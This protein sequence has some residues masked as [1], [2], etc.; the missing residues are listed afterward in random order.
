MNVKKVLA[1][2]LVLVFCTMAFAGCEKSKKVVEQWAY[3]HDEEKAI[4]SFY[5]DGSAEFDGKSYKRYEI[6]NNV[7]TL[8]GDNDE[9]VEMTYV[10]QDDKRFLFRT[11]I[12]H[13]N[14]DYGSDSSKVQGVW[15]TDDNFSFEFTEK[16][17]FLEDGV[18]P[19]YYYVDEE[20][21]TITLMYNDP[22]DDTVIYYSLENGDMI[23]EYPW[24]LIKMEK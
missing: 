14:K 22:I 3:P 12:Y 23:V 24:P 18:L 13:Y 1:L 2:F 19:G 17:T 20:K 15:E 11:M 8:F 10:D 5:K 4:L 9:K 6:A 16:G 21:G 7:I